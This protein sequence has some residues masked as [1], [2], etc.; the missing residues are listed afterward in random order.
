MIEARPSG[1]AFRV[2]LRRAAHQ[3]HDAPP[4]VFTDPFAVRIV[5][6]EAVQELAHIPDTRLR[7]YSAAMRAWVVA[8]AR[9][10]EDVLALAMIS[11][12]SEDS[13]AEDRHSGH[14]PVMQYLVLG[15]GLDTF[16]LRNPHPRLRVFEVDHPATQAW[17]LDKLRAAAL[18][19][20]AS[21]TLAP[22]DFELQ[23]LEGELLAA[24]F[25]P[26]VRTITAWLGVV[27]YLTLDAFRSTSSFLGRLP[28]GSAVVFDYGQPREVLPA[29]EQLMRDSLA[30]R[31]AQVGEPF[32]LF[33]TPPALQLELEAAGL[34]VVED[35]GRDELNERYFAGR[36]DGL[37]VRGSG[38]RLCHAVVA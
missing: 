6:P 15:A 30:S 17:K 38:G 7:P 31:V 29:E 33:F 32:Q 1:T 13:A 12:P 14:L 28:E 11:T 5:G 22:V 20:P 8:R 27:P 23:K 16:A 25:D 4:L 21:A 26:L 34:R 36:L 18:A 10:A 9:F 37:A 3:L 24:G 2:A 35:L 19:L